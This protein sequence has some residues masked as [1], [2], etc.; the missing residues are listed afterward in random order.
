M[1]RIALVVAAMIAAAVSAGAQ[2][3]SPSSAAPAADG[4]VKPGEYSVVVDRNGMRL[5]LSLSADGSTLY[6]AIEAPTTGWVAIGLGSLKMNGAFMVLAYDNAG[7]AFV[8]EETGA[9]YGHKPNPGKRLSASAVKEAGAST[10]LEFAVPAAGLA[11][12]RTVKLILAYGKKDDRSSK[13]SKYASVEL[14]IKR[15]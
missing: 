9:G 5:G 11:D 12:A 6:A 4:V 1:K 15:P 3:L 7:E 2:E 10:T 14:P 8:S 13:H